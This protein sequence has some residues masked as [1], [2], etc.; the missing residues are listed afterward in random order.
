MEQIEGAKKWFYLAAT[1]A[2]LVVAYAAFVYTGSYAKSVQPGNYRSF[3]VTGES[4]I[5][6]KNDVALFTYSVTI[7]GG[8]DIAAIKKESSDKTGKIQA[9][10][11][12]QGVDSKDVTTVA[13]NLEP[14]YQYFQ[15][16]VPLPGAEAR[17]CRPQEIVGYTLSQT[18]SVK[19]RDLTKA[20]KTVSGV[21]DSGANNVSQLTFTVDDSSN[22]QTQAKG[23]A[24][25][26]AI[27]R[28]QILAK[29]AGFKVGRIISID[30]QGAV[31]MSRE[32]FSTMAKGGAA[33]VADTVVNL[34]PGSGDI[35]SNVTVRFEIE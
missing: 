35:I 29:T 21:V 10:L 6:A 32:S 14:R 34:N 8:K 13:Y 22:L 3:A 18:D 25:K 7:Q 1:V 16:S 26:Q 15:C 11:Q 24:I 12:A 2:L 28:A 23:L 9:F 19:I 31:P 5:T 17:P 20:D 30:E 27:L 33:P 4:K